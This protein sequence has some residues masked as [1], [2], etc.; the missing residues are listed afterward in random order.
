M[1]DKLTNRT[2]SYKLV[3]ASRLDRNG[4]VVIWLSFAFHKL[5]HKERSYPFLQLIIET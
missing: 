2:S 5:P 3:K 4:D 1:I